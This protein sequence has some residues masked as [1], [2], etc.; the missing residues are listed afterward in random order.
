MMAVISGVLTTST[1][2]GIDNP[3]LSSDMHGFDGSLWPPN[4]SQITRPLMG[5]L[6]TAWP[7]EGNGRVISG[8]KLQSYS[9]DFYHRIHIIPSSLDL[10]NIISTQT[11]PVKLWNAFLTPQLLLDIAGVD[12]GIELSGQAEPPLSFTALQEREWDV[13]ITPDGP[14]VLDAELQ[15]SFSNGSTAKLTITGNRITAFPWRIDWAD[16]VKEKLTWATSIAQSRTGAE[17]RRMARLAPRR[18]FAT[19]LFL[20]KR[21]R[22]FFDL[23]MFGWAAR[24]WAIPVWFDI[25]QLTSNVISGAVVIPCDTV[26]RDFRANGLAILLGETAFQFETVEI[27]SITPSQINLKR[28]LLQNWSAGTRLYPVRTARLES[29]PQLA[30]L[31]DELQSTAVDFAIVEP[32]EWPAISPSTLYRGRPVYDAT[33]EESQ[34]LTSTL[35][36]LLLRLDNGSAMPVVTDTA[37]L[38]FLIKQHRWLLN[39][40]AEQAA[41]RSFFYFMA[42]RLK[43]VWMP[44]HAD[45]LTLVVQVTESATTMDILAIG[46]TRFGQLKSGRKDIR[47]QM[48][49]GTVYYRRIIGAGEISADVERLQ[50]DSSFGVL[51][52]PANV[53]RISWLML[54]RGDSD[55][56]E[57]EHPVDAEGVATTQQIFRSVRDDDL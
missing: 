42:G 32:C 56:I 28:P 57:I 17:Q 12:D 51:I 40:R 21:E 16:G 30:R 24:V 41:L 25:Q 6:S 7:V 27:L 43:S 4:G 45:D 47:I 50:I 46:Y 5:G 53:L 23:A 18:N 35:Q 36:N 54:M 26:Q 8:V 52:L 33:P 34:D 14:A 37:N 15:W 29:A 48:R 55:S 31:T 11:T 2:G 10:G 13:A 22:Q 49:N 9:D 20:D 38:A 44:T 19:R 3:Y 39:G 1:I